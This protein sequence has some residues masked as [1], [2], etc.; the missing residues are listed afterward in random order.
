VHGHPLRGDFSGLARVQFGIDGA[1]WRISVV[2]SPRG[3]MLFGRL[4]IEIAERY[5]LPV[6]LPLRMPC[7]GWWLSQNVVRWALHGL[8][9]KATVCV[10]PRIESAK[11]AFR[12]TRVAP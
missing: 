9:V 5:C 8:V 12:K 10:R 4:A 7:A 1:G 6:S 2:M 11:T 3:G